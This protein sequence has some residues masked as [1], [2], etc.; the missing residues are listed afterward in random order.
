M[1][2]EKGVPDTFEDVNPDLLPVV[3]ARGY[4]EVTALR[5]KAPGMNDT[6]CPYRPVAEHL[7]VGLGYD[8]PESIVQ[9]RQDN[10]TTWGVTFEE[11][12]AVAC[13]NLRGVSGQ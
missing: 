10:L 13:E 7:A 11:A 5:L 9:I 2:Y 4:Y 12:L 3:R 1:P 8:L 6:G